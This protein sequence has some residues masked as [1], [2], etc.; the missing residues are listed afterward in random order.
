M[1]QQFLVDHGS[2]LFYNHTALFP[3]LGGEEKPKDEGEIQPP[4]DSSLPSQN[5]PIP[6]GMQVEVSNTSVPQQQQFLPQQVTFAPNNYMTPAAANGFG[7]DF[8]IPPDVMRNPR[9]T[10]RGMNGRE[11]MYRV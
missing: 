11:G 5:Q 9:R 6:E 2:P 1:T 3:N 10:T 4:Q 7:S 8:Y